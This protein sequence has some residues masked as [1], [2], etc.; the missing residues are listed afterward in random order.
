MIQHSHSWA[1][2]WKKTIIRQNT[3]TPML[4]AGL[5]IISRH[6]NNLNEPYIQNKQTHRFQKQTY[7][8]QRGN[9][10]G[11]NKLGT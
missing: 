10:G 5:F 3:W 7:G 6:G 11:K 4:T 1:Y 9:Q 2:I 8:Y